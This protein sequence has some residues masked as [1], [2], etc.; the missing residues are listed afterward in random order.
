MSLASLLKHLAFLRETFKT[1]M[2][3]LLDAIKDYMPYSKV[4]GE[5]TD[6]QIDGEQIEHHRLKGGY[7]IWV[8][9]PKYVDT[10]YVAQQ[11]RELDIKVQFCPGERCGVL[12]VSGYFNSQIFHT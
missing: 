2:A 1:R 12:K 4:V 11:G 3:A 10:M 5:H 8:K 7:F 9:L 6:K